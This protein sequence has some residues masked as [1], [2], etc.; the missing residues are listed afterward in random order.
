MVAAFERASR[1]ALV[2][3]VAAIT[4]FQLA[5]HPDLTPGLQRAGVAA[6]AL[7]LLAGPFASGA[8]IAAWIVVAPLA[9]ALLRLAAGREGPVLDIVWKIG[10]AHV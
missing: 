7:G 6:L 2:A 3:S 9:P 4:L 8:G 1:L 5:F 10:R